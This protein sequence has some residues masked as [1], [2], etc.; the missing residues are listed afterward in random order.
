MVCRSGWTSVGHVSLGMVC[1][2]HGPLSDSLS[3]SNINETV[4]SWWKKKEESEIKELTNAI[5]DLVVAITNMDKRLHAILIQM[6]RTDV[7]NV[8]VA[9]KLQ[10]FADAINERTRVA[11]AT[12]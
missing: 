7:I 8:A 2:I 1:P 9:S 12:N 4:M 11:N 3:C 5:E 6:Q 10:Q